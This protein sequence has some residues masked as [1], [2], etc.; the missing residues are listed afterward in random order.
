MK[1]KYNAPTTLTFALA[2]VAV[3]VGNLLSGGWLLQAWFTVPGQGGF[4]FHNPLE[5]LKLFSYVRNLSILLLIGPILE[6]GYG[7]VG[8]L[9]MIL[10]TALITGL[11]NVFFFPQGLCG[12][13]GVAFMMILLASFTNFGKGEIPILHPRHAALPGAG[14]VER[15]DGQ[16]QHQPVRP[17]HRRILRQ[18]LRLLP[19]AQALTWL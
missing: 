9:V 3:F 13:S 14:G 18:P 7:S 5:Y 8:I 10:L 16:G 12:A 11:L 19:P 17:H 15:G 6:E 4:D 2:A 1:F